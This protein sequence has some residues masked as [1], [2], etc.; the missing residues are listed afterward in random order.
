MFVT[1]DDDDLTKK[2]FRTQNVM[3]SEGRENVIKE[4]IKNSDNNI[5]KRKIPLA[6]T[7]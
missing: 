3:K 1:V 6:Y 5:F 7:N 2:V 4:A